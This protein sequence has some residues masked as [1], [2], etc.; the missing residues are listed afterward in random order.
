MNVAVIGAGPS[1][2]V[3]AKSLLQAGLSVTC[4]EAGERIGGQ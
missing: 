1:G 4:F 3:T 2:L